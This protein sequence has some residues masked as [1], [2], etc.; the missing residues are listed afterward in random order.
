MEKRRRRGV[1]LLQS[2]CDD[3][4]GQGDGVEGDVPIAD[5]AEGAMSIV[6]MPM[7][8]RRLVVGFAELAG[9]RSDAYRAVARE[10]AMRALRGREDRRL[11]EQQAS[12]D[13]HERLAC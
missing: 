1:R 5:D 8:L 3:R 2:Q 13:A 10:K 6:M 4:R 9:S 11:Q 12:D 7:V